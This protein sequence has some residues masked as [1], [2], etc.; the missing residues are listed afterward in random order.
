VAEI[1]KKEDFDRGGYRPPRGYTRRH[2]EFTENNLV[3]LQHGM[4]S[5]RVYGPVAE[6]YLTLLMGAIE[7]EHID[8][9]D[10]DK[11]PS[12]MFVLQSLADTLGRVDVGRRHVAE[13]HDTGECERDSCLNQLATFERQLDRRL[14]S[15]GLTPTSRARIAQALT[16]AAQ[17]EA[18]LDTL[19]EKGQAIRERRERSLKG[20]GDDA[21]K[22]G[23]P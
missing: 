13:K 19:I 14:D 4:R 16:S 2:P 23:T 22:D 6:Q 21:D 11:R 20:S 18:T 8:F 15:A 7:A 5:P 9:L 17:N 3:A 12:F 1:K 10:L